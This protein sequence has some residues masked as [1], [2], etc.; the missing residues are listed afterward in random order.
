M[1]NGLAH[2]SEEEFKRLIAGM[3]IVGFDDEAVT[4][5]SSIVRQ[6]ESGLGGVILFDR[7]FHQRDRVKNI[8]N[9]EQLKALAGQLQTVSSEPLLVCVDQ[10]GGKVA[11][12][13]PSYGFAQTPSAA[14]IA[15]GSAS[16]ARALYDTMAGMLADN[17]I[18][19]DFAPSVDLSLNPDNR[20]I[21]AL[22]RSYGDEPAEVIKY[23]SLFS[24]ALKRH[25][26]IS[27]LKHFP[28]H[29]SSLEDSHE[30]F[31]DVTQRWQEIELD[32][33]KA[34]IASGKAQMIMTAHV[35][36]RHLDPEYPATL[37]HPITTGLLRD[38]LGFDGVIVSDDLQ[39]GA[40]RAH[41]TLDETVRLAINAG[42]D[43][44]L[45]GNQLAYDDTDAVIDAIYRQVQSGAIP[46][47]AI[48]KANIRIDAMKKSCLE[49][50]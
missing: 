29:G 31:V 20:V 48:E 43:M 1:D 16:E 3:L 22:E 26:I 30:G 49:A 42:V 32:P 9:P 6:I 38:R 8:R 12:L 19:C 15:K 50:L 44:L 4:P 10:E 21:T 33:Y 2:R 41:Y 28:G 5:R 34:M 14:E 39:M 27:V 24:E 37:S 11:R 13:K 25:G 7:F 17:G 36:N 45:F 23:A 35:F 18:N 40:I 46:S 47:S